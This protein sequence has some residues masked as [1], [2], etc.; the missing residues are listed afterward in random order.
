MQLFS[1]GILYKDYKNWTFM[2]LT[3]ELPHCLG[4]FECSCGQI[5]IGAI[6][7]IILLF[8]TCC[9]NEQHH[10]I[11]AHNFLSIEFSNL[12]NLQKPTHQLELFSLQLHFLNW[13]NCKMLF[14]LLFWHLWNQNS[15]AE[16]S[17]KSIILE[18][19]LL[20]EKL[21]FKAKISYWI[22]FNLINWHYS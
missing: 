5:I 16:C 8:S 11:L 22:N 15:E 6:L 12:H 7:K 17:F 4:F 9:T 1:V 21:L 18:C 3:H 10:S 19:P 2:F 13:N 20:I 14:C